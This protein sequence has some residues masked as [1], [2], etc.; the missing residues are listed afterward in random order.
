[1]I[2]EY[3][4]RECKEIWEEVLPMA[5]MEKPLN[6]KCPHCDAKKG[7]IF[8]HISIAPAMQM[9][10]NMDIKK[11]HNHGG[12]ED[13]MRRMIESPGVKGTPEAEILKGKHL[14]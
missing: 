8:R 13:A 2:Y 10:M 12:F 6:S 5:K 7:S 4:C 1:M 11:P 14:T 3:K 9:D